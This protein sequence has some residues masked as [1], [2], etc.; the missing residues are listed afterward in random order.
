MGAKDEIF[1]E[2]VEKLKSSGKVP[3]AMIE[4]LAKMLENDEVTKDSLSDLVRE[5]LK[6]VDKN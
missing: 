1:V 5:S 6:N 2:V 3:H 4:K